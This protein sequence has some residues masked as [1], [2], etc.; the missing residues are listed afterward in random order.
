LPFHLSKNPQK[1]TAPI[2]VADAKREEDAKFKRRVLDT[3]STADLK[4]IF[5][6]AQMGFETDEEL[7]ANDKRAKNNDLAIFVRQLNEKLD[8]DSARKMVGVLHY[9]AHKF[10]VEEGIE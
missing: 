6:A 10:N 7:E 9:R 2:K 5:L 3:F 8:R 4:I 1:K